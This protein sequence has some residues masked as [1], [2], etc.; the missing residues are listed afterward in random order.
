M[1][2]EV[3][4]WLNCFMLSSLPCFYA[5][6]WSAIPTTCYIFNVFYSCSCNFFLAADA[7]LSW[8]LLSITE[9]KVC[10]HRL[11]M[12]YWLKNQWPDQALFKHSLHTNCI[13]NSAIL[14]NNYISLLSDLCICVHV[15]KKWCCKGSHSSS[16]NGANHLERLQKKKK[17]KKKHHRVCFSSW[18][19]SK[20]SGK[21]L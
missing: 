7:C 18:K 2:G 11:H 19:H 10:P 5:F 21:L 1:Y 3:V 9:Q 4:Y 17:K 12:Q 14:C 13:C 15:K 6:C 8:R 20:M 16:V